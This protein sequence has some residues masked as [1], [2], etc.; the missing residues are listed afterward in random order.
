MPFR[1]A[2]PRDSHVRPP[3][4]T[5]AAHATRTP[6][7]LGPGRQSSSKGTALAP[8]IGAAIYKKSPGLGPGRGLFVFIA[9]F[10]MSVMQLSHFFDFVATFSV[11]V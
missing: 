6:G 11:S 4:S 3:A 10:V 9:T 8:A 7:T 1:P 5:T 2:S